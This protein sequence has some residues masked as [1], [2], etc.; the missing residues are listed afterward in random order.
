MRPADMDAL[1][2]QIDQTR[3]DLGDTIEA[4]AAKTDVRGRARDAIAERKQAMR[5]RISALR[6]R[7]GWMARSGAMA[8]RDRAS[9]MKDTTMH[10]RKTT[11]GM[12]DSDERTVEIL[13]GRGGD[14]M[15]VMVVRRAGEMA[16][17]A[18]RSRGAQVVVGA[19]LGALAGWGA[20]GMLR[21]RLD[22]KA[23]RRSRV[24]A[25]KRIAMEGRERTHR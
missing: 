19:T 17:G 18:A 9:A 10:G 4:L 3:A 25:L 12:P 20:Y 2:D 7:T 23:R 21:Q 24:S 13:G 6:A 22:A 5:D 15:G 16:G 8:A 1:R 14:G 11:P